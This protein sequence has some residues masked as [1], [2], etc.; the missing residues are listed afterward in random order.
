MWYCGTTSDF[1]PLNFILLLIT[2]GA[3]QVGSL[4]STLCDCCAQRLWMFSTSVLKLS[5]DHQNYQVH[6]RSTFTSIT[7]SSS[8]I[9]TDSQQLLHDYALIALVGLSVCSSLTQWL[10]AHTLHNAFKRNFILP[11]KLCCSFKTSVKITFDHRQAA[12]WMKTT[13]WPCTLDS[14]LLEFQN[15]YLI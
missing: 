13:L 12:G 10:S 14:I 8:W 3:Y 2:A 15:A 1:H 4:P 9:N 5:T 11:L 7:L 6:M